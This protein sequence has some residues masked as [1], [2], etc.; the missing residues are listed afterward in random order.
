MMKI[1]A[2]PESARRIIW[3]GC[4]VMK[5]FS[6]MAAVLLLLAMLL[7]MAGCGSSDGK[8]HLSFQ[9]W[10]TN[11]RAG[12]QAMC[13]AYTAKHPDVVIDVQVVSWSEYWTKLEAAAES[14]TMPDI[15]WIIDCGSFFT[16]TIFHMENEFLDIRIGNRHG[17]LASKVQEPFYV[18]EI[19]LP[20]A[21][22][23][24]FQQHILLQFYKI[25]FIH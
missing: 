1:A 8:T 24:I 21:H 15:F 23:E 10:D 5:K 3:K 22:S 14:N 4:G 18:T 20:G 19:I 9:I 13:D 16:F 2:P 7:S 25:F 11:Q 12:M 6:R 17:L